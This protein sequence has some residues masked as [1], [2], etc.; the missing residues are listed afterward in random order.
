M[1]RLY[2]HRKHFYVRLGIEDL[3]TTTLENSYKVLEVK[4]N[5]F[6]PIFMTNDIAL[7]RIDFKSAPVIRFADQKYRQSSKGCEIG[8][9]GAPAFNAPL[10]ERFQVA[11]VDVVPILSCIMNLGFIVFPSLSGSV[12]CGG[13]SLT[14]TCQGDSG[15]ALVCNGV[16]VGI[17]SYG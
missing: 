15:T 6:V 7:M 1:D 16:L 12:L 11:S 10:S 17:T 2:C 13:G 9:F 3:S 5:N 8:G 14:D 4:E